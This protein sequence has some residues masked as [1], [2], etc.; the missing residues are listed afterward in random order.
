M[1]F[2][3]LTTIIVAFVRDHHIWAAPIVFLLAFLEALAFV[4]L[5]VPSTA[6]LLALSALIGAAGL[7]FWPLWLAGGV[8][9]VVGYSLSYAVG[10]Y[11]G[12]SAYGIWPFRNYPGL[13]ARSKAFFDK[14]GV[15]A[16]FFGHFFGPVRA[17]VPVVAGVHAVP[18]LQFEIANIAAAF[19]WITSVL[20][21][22]FLGAG[23][24]SGR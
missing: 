24:L 16:V 10:A 9:G 4:S 2:E 17:F 22:G 11:F 23:W 8:G 15:W 6:I 7:G 13:V 14:W 12:E 18:R 21:P 20:A 1:S 3:S 19:L 5:L